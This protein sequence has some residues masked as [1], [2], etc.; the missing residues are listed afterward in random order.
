MGRLTVIFLVALL[1]LVPMASAMAQETPAATPQASPVA[2]SDR[3]ISFESGP[4]TLYGSLMVPEGA[5][6]PAPGVLIISGS[7]PTDRDGDQP[8]LPTRTNRHFAE[9]L[10]DLGVVSFRYDKLGS[11][12]TGLGTHKLGAGVDYGLFLQ[13]AWDAFDVLA[14]QPEVDPSRIVI[15]GHSE[16]GLFAL[17]MATDASRVARPA[18]LILAAPLSA[19]YFDV[20]REQIGDQYDALAAQGKLTEAQ[21]KALIGQ[22]DE[23][24]AEI[25]ETGKLTMTL[26]DPSLRLLLGPAN[27]AFL[28]QADQRD[29]LKLAA[30]VPDDMPVLIIHGAKDDQV[31]TAQVD[32]LAA[33][34]EASGHTHLTRLDLPDANHIFRVIEGVPDPARDYRDT[35]LPFSPE[36]E[37]ALREFM[38]AFE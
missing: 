38:A 24:I 25:R 20:L 1:A 9:D 33:A 21:A 2:A 6:T 7:G 29:P 10:A 26:A 14:S 23:A 8:G 22:L 30:E 17:D 19:R 11:G 27:V 5:T 15:L 13:E 31:T 32:G 3:E 4:D 35:S 12:K 37:P 18:G 34:F 36:I 16:G 28:Y